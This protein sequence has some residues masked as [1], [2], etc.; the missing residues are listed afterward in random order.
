MSRFVFWRFASALLLG[1]LSLG[2]SAESAFDDLFDD[3]KVHG[4]LSQGY[5]HTSENEYLGTSSNGSLDFNEAGVNVSWTANSSLLLSAQALYKRTGNA[6]PKG[7][8]LDYAMLDWRISDTFDYGAGLRIG[9]LKNPY[10]FYNETRDVPATRPGLSLPESIYLE[11][12]RELIHSSDSLSAYGHQDL[13]SGVLSFDGLFGKPILN[14]NT[15]RSLLGGA[16]TDGEINDERIG[17]ARLSYEDASGLWR[18]AISHAVFSGDFTP[19]SNEPA[20]RAGDVSIKQNLLSTELN[21]QGI[22]FIAE[23]QWRDIEYDD[24]FFN[25][26]VGDTVDILNEGIAYYGQLGYYVTPQWY[27]YIRK[28]DVYLNQDDKDGKAY[29]QT[30]GRPRHNA[31]AKDIVYG[32]RFQ[33]NFEWSFAVEYHRVNGTLWLPDLENP[34]IAGQEQY[35]EMFLL[36][37]AYRF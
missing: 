36:Q 26:F 24:I 1:A 13:G 25:P 34:D 17:L 32:L 19:A 31:F 16:P 30:T 15:V 22:Q 5:A 12:L 27:G 10:G 3:L 11:Y 28:E 18:V 35:W 20:Y 7:T 4:F 23:Y 2:T 29:A 8:R 14:D 33:P 37:A 21:W 9:R 6:K